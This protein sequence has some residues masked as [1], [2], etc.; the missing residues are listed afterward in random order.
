MSDKRIV[1][2]DC[3]R[4][5]ALL[6]R[7][8]NLSSEQET[9]YAQAIAAY[10][11]E[12]YND[13]Q[14][15]RLVRYYY[16]DHQEVQALRDAQN[17]GHQEAWAQWPQQALRFLRDANLDWVSD[18]AVDVEDLVQIALKELH[19]AIASY[20]FSSRFSTWAYTVILR[21]ARHTVRAQHAAKRRGTLIAIDDPETATYL[22]MHS[23]D[24]A[25]MAQSA[26]LITVI[27][28]ILAERGGPRWVEIFQCWA[29]EDKRLVDI[30]QQVGLSAGR[31]SMLLDQML[32]L[33]RDHVD[34]REW[35]RPEEGQGDTRSKDEEQL[36]DAIRETTA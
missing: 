27:N 11:P 23:D 30:G 13:A 15:Q 8:W 33:L 20:H 4:V 10:I 16:L 6:G 26:A 14:L 12:P 35:Y 18:S 1:L 32:R 17:L 3:V 28:G 22:S 9:A 25:V 19:V 24:P 36:G 34:I 31:V 7:E 21:A 5:V 2:A 29:Q